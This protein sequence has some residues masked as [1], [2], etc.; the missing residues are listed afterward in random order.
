MTDISVSFLPLASLQPVVN[1]RHD[2]LGF[3]LHSVP[4]DAPTANALITLLNETPLLDAFGPLDCLLPVPDPMRIDVD[5]MS[6]LPAEKIVL[7]V[8]AVNCAEAETWRRVNEL[9]S[10]GFRILLEGV[11]PSGSSVS[12]AVK[13]LAIHCGDH[14]SS[15][16]ENW[17]HRLDGPHLAENVNDPARFEACRTAGFSWFAGSYPL[18]RKVFPPQN[19]GSSRTRLLMLLGLVSHD[20]ETREIETLLKQDPALSYLLLKLVNSAVFGLTTTVTSFSQAI[21]LLGRRQLQRWLQLLL[22]AGQHDGDM[23]NPLLGRAAF[24]AGLMEAL[25]QNTG[26]NK[27]EQN[28]AFMAG[29]F[30]LL[31]ALFGLPMAEIIKPLRLEESVIAALLVRSGKLGMLLDLAE[32]AASDRG[33]LSNAIL[34]KCDIDIETYWNSMAH[35]SRWAVEVSRTFS[36]D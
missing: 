7:R 8:S 32:R 4:A 25:C 17:M 18:H 14:V 11:P 35:A 34:A 2:W 1:A 10:Q 13:S 20:A 24:R 33:P 19:N 31:D 12:S 15:D 5:A 9:Q 26:G 16:I 21:S 36:H 22:Y 23:D 29:L 28:A 6:R 30:S 3:A 27:D